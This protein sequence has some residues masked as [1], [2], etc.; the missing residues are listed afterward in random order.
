[1]APTDAP[2]ADASA[3]PAPAP[4]LPPWLGPAGPTPE[5]IT[6]LAAGTVR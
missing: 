3:A 1:M 2:P 6:A 4:V 5:S